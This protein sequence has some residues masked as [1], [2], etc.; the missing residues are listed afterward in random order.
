MERR[1]SEVPTAGEV[2]AREVG[3]KLGRTVLKTPGEAVVVFADACMDYLRNVQQLTPWEVMAVVDLLRVQPPRDTAPLLWYL[4]DAVTPLG[5]DI[6]HFVTCPPFRLPP[7]ADHN[8][9]AGAL[10][11][12]PMLAHKHFFARAAVGASADT[13]PSLDIGARHEIRLR[14]RSMWILSRNPGAWVW[15]RLP[16]SHRVTL[17]FG[18][19]GK[20]CWAFSR[21][22][23]SAAV[24]LPW[25][26]NCS[27]V[28]D[29]VVDAARW[30][31]FAVYD[32]MM[33]GDR[34]WCAVDLNGRMA[35]LLDS[36][37]SPQCMGVAKYLP[38]DHEVVE[39][40]R[41]QCF[42]QPDSRT[43]LLFVDPTM[44][45]KPA[46]VSRDAC[47]WKPP[48]PPG[49]AVLCCRCGEAMSL[50]AEDACLLWCEGPVVG[51]IEH[52]QSYEC[53]YVHETQSWT[54]VRRAK[55]GEPL[56]TRDQVQA[57]R[58]GA[59]APDGAYE[60]AA[61]FPAPKAPHKPRKGPVDADG[62]ATV[63]RRK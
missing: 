29:C 11:N 55:R 15:T 40:A 36:F 33:L 12:F 5:A 18:N 8:Q 4:A 13:R 27:A 24:R 17:V 38:A 49:H 54:V 59:P 30:S 28:L 19:G 23:A 56:F 26:A 58:F 41:Q 60:L 20:S 35:A 61:I 57:M 62:F 53:A 47:T 34:N 14:G 25:E 46:I 9:T 48:V 52:M 31:H 39:A 50:A 7:A 43:R 10:P 21:A 37:L 32:A 3:A 16:F 45:Y 22:D 42:E 44:P 63:K 2:A 51:Q 1:I 6:V